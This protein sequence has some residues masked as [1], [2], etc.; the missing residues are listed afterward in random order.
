P[1]F[2]TVDTD[3]LDTR[4]LDATYWYRN[5]RNTVR[6]APAI[7]HLLTQNFTTYIEISAHPV[8]TT[9]IEATIEH[10][11]PGPTLVTGTLRRGQGDTRQLLTSLGHAWTRGT[12][13]NW[14]P[15]LDPH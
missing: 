15:L 8:L 10:T 9:S 3:W 14:T 5:L 13:I 4:H 6:F 11:E 12:P 2:S 7:H 1:F